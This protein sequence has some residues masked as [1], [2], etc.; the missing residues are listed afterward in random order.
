MVADRR[1]IS[2]LFGAVLTSILVVV[3]PLTTRAS[4]EGCGPE[5][6]ID[7]GR[8]DECRNIVALA[9]G[10]D[11]RVNL[12][13]LLLDRDG[14]PPNPGDAIT[15]PVLAW[16]EL[17]KHFS[18]STDDSGPGA[19]TGEG[20]LCRSDGAGAAG[21][22]T[23]VKAA[24]GVSTSER[25][26][27]IHARDM[28]RSFCSGDHG[29]DS[30]QDDLI[31]LLRTSTGKA[32]A[33]YLHGAAAFYGERFSDA[34][35][36]FS[37][38]RKSS[39]PW[40]ADAADYMVAR[41]D[42]NRMQVGA[43][44]AY[45]SFKGS[46]HVDQQAAATAQASLD[47]Y[48]SKHPDGRYVKSA[49]GLMRRVA[50][51]AGWTEKLA[52]LYSA[53]LAQPASERGVDD[54]SLV[55]EIDD[56]LL[57]KLKPE[58]TRDPILL[59]VLD[60]RNMRQP[61]GAKEDGW[62]ARAISRSALDAQR[63]AFEA[64][65]P[66]WEFLSAADA[67]YVEG[68]SEPVI[69]SLRDET[70]RRDGDYLWFSRQFLRGMAL[71]ARNDRNTQG[72]WKE[73]YPAA[74]RPF[75]RS[76]IELAL[77]LHDQRHAD[78]TDV[79]APGS[80][81][82]NVDMREILAE[83]VAAP[84]VLRTLA[85]DKSIS[86]GERDTA[87]FTLLRKDLR[88]G[89]YAAFLSDMSEIADDGSVNATPG[90]NPSSQDRRLAIFATSDN[91]GDIACPS[92]KI[93]AS[94]LAQRPGAEQDRLCLAEFVRLNEAMRDPSFEEGG[95][96]S[97]PSMFPGQ[98]LTRA[99]VYQG[100]IEDAGAR[101]EDRAYALYRAVKCYEPSG[102]NRCGG[103]DVPKAERRAWYDALKRDYPTS[104]WAND[105]PYWW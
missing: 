58:M 86:Q 87:L 37:L 25:D 60:L 42:V 39:D 36:D 82:R 91:A 41:T 43:F 1:L 56:K 97:A 64:A 34:A 67:F 52:S 8:R 102:N 27:L 35:D 77:A 90:S 31:P 29:G 61:E 63:A 59:A 3:F 93:I 51:L 66:L 44:D 30:S 75:E 10:N 48:I 15:D 16:R 12:L 50:W 4:T 7:P 85:H 11:T 99:A 17:A 83:T 2:V 81:V 72:F 101:A 55:E 21:F 68:T 69:R 96:G 19:A 47:D 20:S 98:S 18:T 89:F 70:R 78:M 84:S 88:H 57:P 73:L 26:T 24:N 62:Q 49:R 94:H 103:A 45:G 32:F 46:E 23:A 6:K 53:L 33:T 38:V 80:L 105:L 71:E 40:L 74:N 22:I 76:T 104:R 14:T 79:F 9:P 100:I 13:L 5:W 28:V 92:L 54:L 65:M 95:L